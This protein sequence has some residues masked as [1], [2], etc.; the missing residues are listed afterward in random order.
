MQAE[1]G[2]DRDGTLC[3]CVTQ[4]TTIHSTEDVADDSVPPLAGRAATSFQCLHVSR[5]LA[6]SAAARMRHVS[7]PLGW[8]H[9]MCVQIQ[10]RRRLDLTASRHRLSHS[11]CPAHRRGVTG[12]SPVSFFFVLGVLSGYVLQKKIVC[13][14]RI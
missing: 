9:A 7:Y 10:L 13:C 4:T 3:V 12:P 1:K 2:A 8:R 6:R 5:T 11:M 14:L